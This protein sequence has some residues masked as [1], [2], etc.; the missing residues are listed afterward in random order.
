VWRRKEEEGEKM[1]RKRNAFDPS[2]SATNGGNS[3]DFASLVLR[4]AGWACSKRR[5]YG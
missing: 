3:Y 2:K 4:V 1:L 5:K